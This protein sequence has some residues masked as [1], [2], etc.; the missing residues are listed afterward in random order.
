MS[1]LVDELLEKRLTLEE[2]VPAEGASDSE[3]LRRVY[4][5]LTGVIP[6]VADVRTFAA[7]THPDKR[8]LLIDELLESPRH[9]THMANTWRQ[10]MLPGGVDFDQL[11]SIAGVQNWL[12][13]QFAVNLR[14]DRIVSDFLVASGGGETGPALFYTSLDLQPEKLAAATSRI[15]LGLQ[16]EC[17]E[18]HPHPFDRWTQADFWGYTAFFARLERSASMTAGQISLV[19]LA[20]GEVTLPDTE[21]VVMPKFPDGPA[22]NQDGGGS[23]RVQLAIWMASRDNPYLAQATVNRVWAHLF[24]QGLVEPVDDLGPHNPAS[25]PELMHRLT[26]HFTN[27]GF[28]MRELLRVLANTR[29]YQRSSRFQG[30]SPPAELYARMEMKTL[31]AE[32]LFDCLVR[33][34]S[35]PADATAPFLPAAQGPFDP[36][37]LA[38]AAKMQ[39]RGANAT[40][41]E[42]GVLQALTLLNGQETARL[43]APEDS[44][45]LLGLTAPWFDDEQRLDVLFLATLSRPPNEAEKDQCR[46]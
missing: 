37:R 24:G 32:Q 6:R 4:L 2:V 19:D 28:D 10:I 35:R 25:H 22:A 9:A 14:Y 26:A 17:A 43:T 11:Q 15:F 39:M 31:S 5:N 38:F 3:F 16:I 40:E 13:R 20:E 34:I 12:R 23:R 1:E 45:L 33:V 18:C 44:G 42:A 41:F 27:S 29:A 46:S 21:Q 36:R 8:R 7:D 30:E